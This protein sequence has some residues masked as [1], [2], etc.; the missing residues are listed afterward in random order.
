MGPNPVAIPHPTP[1]RT[2]SEGLSSRRLWAFGT[3]RSF[4]VFMNGLWRRVK[5]KNCRQQLQAQAA[6]HLEPENGIASRRMD[7]SSLL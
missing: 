3:I 2:G 6:D 5:S 4:F 1:P 7:L